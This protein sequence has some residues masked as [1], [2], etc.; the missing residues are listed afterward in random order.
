MTKFKN[1]KK[2]ESFRNK[3][4][5]KNILWDGDFYST[6]LLINELT[7]IN[8]GINKFNENNNIDDNE[9]IR[10]IK[11]RPY[12]YVNET[13]LETE[14]PNYIYNDKEK[15]KMKKHIFCNGLK[16]ETQKKLINKIRQNTDFNKILLEPRFIIGPRLNVVPFNINLASFKTKIKMNKELESMV[17]EH[18]KSIGITFNDHMS[19]FKDKEIGIKYL[20]IYR[21]LLH[22]NIKA[23]FTLSNKERKEHKFIEFLINIQSSHNN[24]ILELILFNKPKTELNKDYNIYT[25][26]TWDCI[27][28][29]FKNGSDCGKCLKCIQHDKKIKNT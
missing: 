15:E 20:N 7:N 27:N 12:I 22:H 16:I 11:L 5:I 9:K 13:I 1:L 14:N 26:I 29:N 18:F 25:Q 28:P 8:D 21:Y 10:E 2:S 4:I 23:K 6:Y 3:Y 17:N 19:L 24:N